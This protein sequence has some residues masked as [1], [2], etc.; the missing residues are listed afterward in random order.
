MEILPQADYGTSAW[1]TNFCPLSSARI[2]PAFASGIQI[3]TQRWSVQSTTQRVRQ[4]RASNSCSIT[5]GWSEGVN[6]ATAAH[7][8]LEKVLSLSSHARQLSEG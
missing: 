3:S 8:S 5:W 6:G 7:L 1:Q 4:P 2:T